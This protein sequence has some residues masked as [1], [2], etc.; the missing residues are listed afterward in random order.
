MQSECD[1]V[2]VGDG[3]AGSGVFASR[4]FPATAVIG[5]IKGDL[6]QD[7]RLETEYTF[8]AAEG[9]QLEPSAPFRFLNHSCDHNCE[10]DWMTASDWKGDPESVAEESR[11][12]LYLTALRNISPG[13]EL[14]IDYNWPAEFAIKCECGSKNCRG[15]VVSMDEIGE[16]KSSK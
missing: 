12:G 13:E 10:F 5:Q 1:A 4:A 3:I 11:G 7:Q 9:Y 14:T 6:F 15:Y 16:L 8:Q 2:R